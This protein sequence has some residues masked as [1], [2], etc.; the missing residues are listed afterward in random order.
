MHAY[1]TEAIDFCGFKFVV[2]LRDREIQA[3]LLFQKETRKP[4]YAKYDKRAN[5]FFSSVSNN[6]PVSGLFN[7]VCKI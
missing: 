4:P 3:V 1:E 7:K 6:P 5:S 2:H